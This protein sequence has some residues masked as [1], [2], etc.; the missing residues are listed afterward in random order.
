MGVN[1]FPSRPI[2]LKQ[3]EFAPQK[4]NRAVRAPDGALDDIKLEC[5]Y[6]GIVSSHEQ[7]RIPGGASCIVR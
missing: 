7:I 6:S 1:N 5:T 4:I 3:T 2:I